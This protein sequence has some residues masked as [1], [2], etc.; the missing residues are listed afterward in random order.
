ME[1]KQISELREEG[2]DEDQRWQLL[3]AQEDGLDISKYCHLK[4]T[5]DQ[6]YILRCVQKLGLDITDLL[7]QMERNRK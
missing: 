1:I 7:K 5:W 4:Y 3:M 2:F 6:M